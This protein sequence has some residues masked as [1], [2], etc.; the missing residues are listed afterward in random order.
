MERVSSLKAKRQKIAAL[1]MLLVFV[2][3]VFSGI[4]FITEK[5]GHHCLDEK[6]SV[7]C[8][9]R[10]FDELF[11]R[12]NTPV[13]PADAFSLALCVS[14]MIVLLY[15]F[16]AADISLVSLKVKLSN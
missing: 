4:F 2:F 11:H 1:I 5:S 7:C 8:T 14:V 12:G 15:N 9:M 16:T 10:Q 6:C 3:A 13:K